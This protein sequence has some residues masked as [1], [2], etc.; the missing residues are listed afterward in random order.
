MHLCDCAL[1]HCLLLRVKHRKHTGWIEIFGRGKRMNMPW[2]GGFDP[3]ACDVASL[4]DFAAPA[5]R[6]FP[7]PD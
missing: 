2:W 6:E 7:K 3:R 5:W 4:M 1:S